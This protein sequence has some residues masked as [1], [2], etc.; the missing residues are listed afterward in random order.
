MIQRTTTEAP[1]IRSQ[2][3]VLALFAVGMIGHA[4]PALVYGD[5]AMDYG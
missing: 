4:T 3:R 1:M 5:F 2:Q